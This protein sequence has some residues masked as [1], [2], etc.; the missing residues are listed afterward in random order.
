MQKGRVLRLPR[1]REGSQNVPAEPILQSVHWLDAA[2]QATISKTS[3]RTTQLIPAR[4][5]NV[6]KQNSFYELI[7][8]VMLYYKTVGTWNTRS[9]CLAL[10]SLG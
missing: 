4:V 1:E 10:I 3:G 5:Q 8:F 9:M 2:T 6:S 7:T